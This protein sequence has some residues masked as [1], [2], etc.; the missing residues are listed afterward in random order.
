MSR[1]NDIWVCAKCHNVF[2]GDKSWTAGGY[3]EKCADKMVHEPTQFHSQNWVKYLIQLRDRD[4]TYEQLNCKAH[5]FQMIPKSG[6]HL[7]IPLW[8]CIY[9][10]A[11]T[12]ST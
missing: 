6:M 3:C 9:C 4:W 12:Q 11:V 5:N 8:R 1:V 2:N 7:G 10:E